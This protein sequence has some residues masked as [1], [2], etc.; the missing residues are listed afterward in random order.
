M[1]LFDRGAS[2]VTCLQAGSV[3]LAM[4]AIGGACAAPLPA[5]P[6]AETNTKTR[7]AASRSISVL[8]LA[9]PESRQPEATIELPPADCTKEACLALT[10][11]DGPDTR[12]TPM[13]LSLLKDYDVQVTFFVLGSQVHKYPDLTKQVHSDGHEIGNHSWNHSDYTKFKPV[14]ML[15]D[16]DRTQRLLEELDIPT[17]TLFR[18]PYGARTAAVDATIPLSIGLWNVD[19]KDWAFNDAKKLARNVLATAKPGGIVVLHDVKP[20]TVAAAKVFIPELMKKYRLVTV[21][22]LTGHNAESPKGVVSSQ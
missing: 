18:P 14:Q 8:P 7:V 6:P 22:H 16:F 20:T 13:L 10:F 17:P 9:M 1:L 4:A 21:S 3:G 19:P 5:A 2:L 15:D 12:T 11:D